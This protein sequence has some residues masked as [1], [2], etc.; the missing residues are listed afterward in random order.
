M[1]LLIGVEERNYG[2]VP[3][4]LILGLE[5]DI[6]KAFAAQ[7]AAAGNLEIRHGRRT[8]FPLSS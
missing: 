6:W 2:N 7:E 1:T 8:E 3:M 5:S 4:N